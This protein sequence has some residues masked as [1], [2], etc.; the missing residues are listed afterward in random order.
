[1]SI[2][3]FFDYKMCCSTRRYSLHISCYNVVMISNFYLIAC[4]I[5]SELGEQLMLRRMCLRGLPS[6]KQYT[7]ITVC[8]LLYY[9][10]M[11][12]SDSVQSG[13]LLL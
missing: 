4:N 12:S 7:G 1:M 6:S 5:S 2:Y 10:K 11:L 8:I 3:D 9:H 13:N